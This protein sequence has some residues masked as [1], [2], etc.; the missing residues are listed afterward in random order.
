MRKE[1]RGTAP[2]SD[3]AN[4]RGKA[5]C[6]SKQIPEERL[7]EM[8][9]DVDLDAAETMTAED[10]NILRIR[11][12]GGGELVRYWKDRSRS[13]SWTA[14]MRAEAGRKTKERNGKK[15]G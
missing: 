4:T 2:C 8:T 3:T 12:K 14:E 7:Y 1:C 9:A 10:G 13:E 11:L 5:F 15:N 6:P